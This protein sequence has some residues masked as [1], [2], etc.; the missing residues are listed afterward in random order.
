MLQIVNLEK[1]FGSN[2][3]LHNI[4]LTCNYGKIYGIIGRNGSGKS[5]LFKCI[6]G[7][8]QID[9]GKILIDEKNIYT[10]PQILKKIGMLI[11]TPA[12]LTNYSG[13]DNLMMLYSINNRISP[14]NIRY[15]MK[16]VGLNPFDRKK[17]YKYSMG[18]KQRLA[19]AQAIM[20]NQDILILDEP[21][22]GLDKHGVEEIKAL[23]SSVKKDKIIL[24]TSHNIDD[25][26]QLCDTVYEF[27]DGSL[28][29]LEMF[30][31]VGMRT[32][33]CGMR[34]NDKKERQI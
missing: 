32:E 2:T 21:F 22:N 31:D 8:I 24:L 29:Q 3:I 15:Y 18:M 23:L 33:D 1:S 17:V 19:I 5:V 34:T 25:I 16:A 10:N 30:P 13:F 27:E 9:E 7:L 28:E 4:N 26:K 12:F 14:D 11:E 6:C 20:E